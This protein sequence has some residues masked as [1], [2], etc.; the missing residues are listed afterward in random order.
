[1]RVKGIDDK[2]IESLSKE[3][4]DYEPLAG[5]TSADIKYLQENLLFSMLPFQKKFIRSCQENQFT[6]LIKSRRIGGSFSISFAIFLLICQS[7]IA[8]NFNYQSRVEATARAVLLDIKMW[9]AI[10]GIAVKYSIVEGKDCKALEIAF[11]NGCK[12]N[13]LSSNLNAWAGLSGN[14]IL[15][16]WALNK[17]PEQLL[18]MA[19]PLATWGGRIIALTTIRDP[20][21]YVSK[22]ME[23]I[24]NG[25]N[26]TGW[27]FIKV[28]LQQAIDEGLVEK[29]NAVKKLKGMDTQTNVEYYE[30]IKAASPSLALFEREF[31]CIPRDVGNDD[32]NTP[33]KDYLC[34]PI[35]YEWQEIEEKRRTATRIKYYGAYDVGRAS[36]GDPSALT[37]YADCGGVLYPVE[38]TEYQGLDF[39]QQKKNVA[40]AIKKYKIVKMAIDASSLGWNLAED[41][42]KKF[43]RQILQVKMYGNVINRLTEG[44]IKAMQDEEF[45][46]ANEK[47]IRDS[48]HQVRETVDDKGKKS[49]WINRVKT[50]DKQSHGDIAVTLLLV[51]E[52]WRSSR[53][54]VRLS[55]KKQSIGRV[56]KR[57]KNRL[58]SIL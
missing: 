27:N 35:S 51:N 33:F 58:G 45:I 19:M 23:E 30:S 17:D 5:L 43:P 8:E 37:I 42:E 3:F 55:D 13:I 40:A 28:T 21:N 10:A 31:C 14:V 50:K 26:P 39:A 46:I 1:M 6:L 34:T 24:Q 11:P 29:T 36:D 44:L 4:A 18:G 32:Q 53:K 16:E 22:L 56:G 2:S 7:K 38:S 49:Y 57:G 20:E 41:L 15:D 9:L 25:H 54:P 47:R 52:A 12:L 48:L